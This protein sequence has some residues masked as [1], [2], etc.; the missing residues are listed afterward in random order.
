MHCILILHRLFYTILILHR[1]YYQNRDY[2]VYMEITK[3]LNDLGTKAV[4]MLQSNLGFDLYQVYKI[5]V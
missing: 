4:K 3:S 1:L 2:Q 5:T